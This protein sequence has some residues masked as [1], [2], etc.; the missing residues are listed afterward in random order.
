MADQGQGP[1]VS[2]QVGN[3]PSY[4]TLTAKLSP[5]G[6]I[7]AESGSMIAHGPGIAVETK[8]H[9]GFLGAIGKIVS[10]Q[11]MFVSTYTASGSSFVS[12]APT[13]PGD[14]THIP[15]S[16]PRRLSAGSFLAHTDGVSLSTVF[17]GCSSLFG[18]SGLFMLEASGQGDLFVAGFGAISEIE[19]DGTFTLDTGHLVAWDA[20]LAYQLKRVGGWKST[21]LSGEGLVIEFSGR[22]KVLISSRNISAFV[23]WLTPWLPA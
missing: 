3:R 19:V 23:S 1:G 8:M 15:I 21:F 9:G 18:G 20:G 2:W 11:S 22:G 6:T 13:L 7:V 10:R 12:L 5:G 14:I 17:G 16:G 4:A